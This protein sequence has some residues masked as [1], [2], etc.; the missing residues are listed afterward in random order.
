MVLNPCVVTIP[1]LLTHYMKTVSLIAFR[2]I[3]VQKEPEV[4]SEFIR[5]FICWNCKDLG[6]TYHDCMIDLRFFCFGC[7]RE[8]VNKPD[9]FNCQKKFMGNTHPNAYSRGTHSDVLVK[10][11]VSK[12]TESTSKIFNPEVLSPISLFH[13]YKKPFNM[14][15]LRVKNYF[16]SKQRL[17]RECA[18]LLFQTTSDYLRPRLTIQI[19]SQKFYALC[20]G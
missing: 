13:P 4:N 6:H 7:G 2:A 3:N 5:L 18:T 19:A 20:I 8:N 17:I 14:R 1:K 9:C 12:T 11:F 10:P 15:L 16:K